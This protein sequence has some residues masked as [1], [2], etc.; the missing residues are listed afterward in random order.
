MW[1]IQPGAAAMRQHLKA[2]STLL[3]SLVAYYKL[4]EASGTRVDATGRGNDLSPTNTPG[5]T[6]GQIGSAVSLAAAS[7]QYLGRASTTDLTFGDTDFTLAM[8]IKYTGGASY[9]RVISKNGASG[10][11]EFQLALDTDT[12]DLAFAVFDASDASAEVVASTF[13]ALGTG[14]WHLIVMWHD[15][16]ANTVNIQV[17]GGTVDSAGTSGL[18]VNA[19]TA[20]FM[21][22]NAAFADRLWNGAID[23]CGV[24]KR[25]LTSGERT[26][27]YN[28]GSGSTYPFDFP[29]LVFSDDFSGASLDTGKWNNTAFAPDSTPGQPDSAYV[30]TAF[31]FPGSYLRIRADEPPASDPYDYTSGQIHTRNKFKQTY[32]RWEVRAKFPAGQG[33]KTAIWLVRYDAV[34]EYNLPEFDIVETYNDM[35]EVFC[36]YH[37]DDGGL[38]SAGGSYVDDTTDGFHTYTLDWRPNLAIWYYDGHEVLRRTTFVGNTDAFLIINLSLHGGPDETT[39][40]PSYMDIDYVRVWAY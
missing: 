6:T 3:N 26:S 24:W 4:E 29:R 38:T 1:A 37:W 14:V 25:V 35:D 31:E 11:K 27:L 15:S 30:T 17:D 20:T 23:E 10:N 19:S 16:G 32:G 8:W 40:F 12:G 39:P 33:L 36:T 9:P 2:Q 18:V 7:T 22:G 28:G 34:V 5:N 13:G 21:L